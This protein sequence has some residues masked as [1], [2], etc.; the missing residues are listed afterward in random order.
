[1]NQ[2]IFQNFF[3]QKVFF[4]NT[5]RHRTFRRRAGRNQ[6]LA[7]NHRYYRLH[8]FKSADFPDRL[9]IIV[10]R[11]ARHRHNA[12]MAVNAQNTRQKLMPETVHYRHYDNQRRYAERNSRKGK[13][14][15][16][17]NKALAALGFQ[18]PPRHQS[19]KL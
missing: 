12:D 17:R 11:H 14:G 16:Y 9:Q 5:A 3:L 6:Q 10:E 1:M 15:N 4:G 7:L 19:L 2:A 8:M 18:I 13:A